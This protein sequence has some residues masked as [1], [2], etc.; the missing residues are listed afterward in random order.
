[1]NILYPTMVKN[2]YKELYD[3][4]N[5]AN[6]IYGFNDSIYD[7]MSSFNYSSTISFRKTQSS[8]ELILT[9][10]FYG[11]IVF[12]NLVF[13]LF[14]T[15]FSNTYWIKKSMIHRASPKKKFK[16]YSFSNQVS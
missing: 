4:A 6:T 11:F 8:S 1:M 12:K 2:K 15:N 16:S 9:D 13:F 7:R 10:L 5:S 14:Q 3:N